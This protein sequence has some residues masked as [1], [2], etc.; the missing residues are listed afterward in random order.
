[1]HVTGRYYR[2]SLCGLPNAGLLRPGQSR[3]AMA[4]QDIFADI[5]VRQSIPC[6]LKG[7]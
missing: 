7:F 6:G 5:E 2:W 4:T 3:A 1:M